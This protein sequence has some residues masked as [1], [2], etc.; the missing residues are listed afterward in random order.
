M[1]HSPSS[2]TANS[3]GEPLDLRGFVTQREEQ[4][5]INRMVIRPL[6]DA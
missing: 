5:T 3:I 4:A 6:P 1:K 2:F